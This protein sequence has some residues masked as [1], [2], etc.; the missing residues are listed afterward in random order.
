MTPGLQSLQGP[1]PSQA[2]RGLVGC[3]VPKWGLW[4]GEGVVP[5]TE[6]G[7]RA[8]WRGTCRASLVTA[9]RP[10]PYTSPRLRVDPRPHLDPPTLSFSC[11]PLW[12]GAGRPWGRPV[13][14]EPAN[15]GLLPSTVRHPAEACPYLPTTPPTSNTKLALSAWREQWVRPWRSPLPLGQP[16]NG[17]ALGRE[18]LTMTSPEKP[19]DR[20]SRKARREADGSGT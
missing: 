12:P 4:T 1:P 18:E 16:D 9:P 20:E 6:G 17:A 3:D 10:S 14:V 11:S 19:V 2:E 5:S 15:L 8:L 13:S 7:A